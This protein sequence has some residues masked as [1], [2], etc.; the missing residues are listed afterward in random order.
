M[1]RVVNLCNEHSTLYKDRKLI[2]TLQL[3]HCDYCGE[4]ANYTAHSHQ[5]E[6]GIHLNGM[7]QCIIC[8]E[9]ITMKHWIFLNELE[10]RKEDE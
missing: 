2:T 4:P 5:F 9:W 6:K 7:K 3:V 1:V 8:K 10:W